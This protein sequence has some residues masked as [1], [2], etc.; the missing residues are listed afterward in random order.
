[1]FSNINKTIIKYILC[2]FVIFVIIAYLPKSKLS[3]N[4]YIL[5][6]LTIIGIYIILDSFSYNNLFSSKNTI[7]NKYSKEDFYDIE[8]FNQLDTTDKIKKVVLDNSTDKTSPKSKSPVNN[9]N[10]KKLSVSPKTETSEASTKS[11]K[12]SSK[13]SKSSKKS[14]ESPD[15]NSNKTTETSPKSD[16]K[17]STKI[18]KKISPVVIKKAKVPV[19]QL[20]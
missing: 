18:V 13:S 12:K 15:S 2:A 8:N 16:K 6:G 11:S 1:M 5:L 4:S 17:K 14:T 7:N 20:P 3:N 10:K 9:K 19:K